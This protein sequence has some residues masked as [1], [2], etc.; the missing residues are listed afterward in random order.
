MRVKSEEDRTVWPDYV[1][2]IGGGRWARVLIEV[3]CS[4]TPMSV[5]ISVHSPRNFTVMAGWVVTCGLE[6]RIRVCSDYPKPIAGKKGAVVVANAAHDHERAIE[7]ALYQRLPVLVEKPVTLSFSATQRMVDLANNQNTYL[8]T[9]HVFLFAS[10]IETFSK[11]VSNEN[12]IVSIRVLWSDP[13]NESR[14]GE[15]KNYDSGLPIYADWLPHIVSILD[16]FTIGPAILSENISFFRGGAHLKINLLY[17]QIPCQIELARNHNSRQ[18]TIEVNTEKKKITLDFSREP[19]VIFINAKELC[20][21]REWGHKPKPVSNMLSAFLQTAAGGSCD[22]RLD[23]SIGLS[24][25]QLIDQTTTFYRAALLPWLNS[26]LEKHPD[27][28][29]SDLRYALAEILQMNDSAS[30]V[31]IEQR[32]NYLYRNLKEFILTSNDTTIKRIDDAVNLIIKQGKNTS[33]L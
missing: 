31:P 5:K 4:I 17:G 6:N 33:Y 28:I 26:E 11:L 10:Y 12:A 15:T 14:Y 8:A 22:A 19:G 16:A 24:A 30:I 25:S 32:I 20:G 21:D 18:R 7:W 29:S 13:K 1:A 27:T 23:H 9:A 3:I 2:V